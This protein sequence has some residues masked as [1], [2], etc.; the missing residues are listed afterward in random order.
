[1]ILKSLQR[2]GHELASSQR[3]L[4]LLS[5]P[6]TN[7]GVDFQRQL[8]AHGLSE[9]RRAGL[10]TLQINVGRVC[11][12]TCSH[13][14]VDA[15]PDRRENMSQATAQLVID[16]LDRGSFT[17]LDITGGAPEMNPRFRWL[18]QEARQRQIRVID[19][20]NLT[21]LLAAGFTDLPQFLAQHQVQIVA[22]LP[23]YLEENCDLQRGRGVFARSITGLQQLNQVGYG[24]PDSPLQLDLVYNPV[25]AKLPPPQAELQSVY[26][27]QLWDRYQVRF[28]R[29]LTITNM[30]ISRFLVEL[31]NSQQLT[32]YLQ[33][34]SQ[35]FN[36]ATLDQLMCRWLV[37]VDWQGYLYDC[38]FNQMLNLGLHDADGSR[39]HLSQ[40]DPRDLKRRRIAT[41]NHCLGCTAGCGSSCGGALT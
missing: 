15:G 23:C 34:L 11:N 22:S 9:L 31:V 28:N 2:V 1:M 7:G 29:L 20:C 37:S 38:D 12:Q 24:Q 26:R 30:P 6:L 16:F 41:A 33:D 25:G 10:E 39:L 13:C 5:D 19:R 8:A 27:E 32:N 35:H 40:V 4:Q 3:Q 17:T 14:H 18:V 36:P 21:I